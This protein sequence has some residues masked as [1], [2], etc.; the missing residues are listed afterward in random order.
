MSLQTPAS[1]LHALVARA[2]SDVTGYDSIDPLVAACQDPAKGDYQSNAAMSVSGRLKKERGR[3]VNPRQLA[4]DV[5]ARIAD[6]ALLAETPQVAGPGFINF[7][8]APTWV[9]EQATAAL[10]DDRLGIPAAADPETVVVEYSSPNIAKQ[11]HVGHIRSTILGD[12]A[13]RVLDFLGHDVIRQNHVGDWGTQFGMLIARLDEAGGAADASIGDLEAFYR[14]SKRRFD[15][16]DDFKQKAREAVVRLQSGESAERDAWQRLVDETRKDYLPIYGRLNVGLTVDDER[17]ESFYNPKLAEI[18]EEL[19]KSGVAE[20]SDGALVSF[21]GDFKSPLM[22]RKSDGG[23][24]YGT[25]DLAAVRF[26]ATELDAD[27]VL[28]FVD[29]RQGQHFAQIF[30]TAKVAAEKLDDWRDVGR[31][32]YEHA[33]FGSVL[34]EGGRPL[35]TRDGGTIKLA[36]LL[37][38]A[39]QRARVVVDE[40]TPNLQ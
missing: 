6:N 23:Y 19:E 15:D 12:C 21:A 3:S 34:G 18:A 37:D 30:A 36:D 26:R 13:A 5:V 8:L 35:K 10:C 32:S 22:I 33:S 17:G 14:E 11:M 2:F 9:A 40:S 4:T 38:E 27:R 28:Y 7:R 29:A 39:E 31:V 20:V 16:D 24:C 25:T 1:A